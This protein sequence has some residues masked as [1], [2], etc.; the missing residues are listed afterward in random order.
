MSYHFT[1]DWFSRNIPEWR[2]HLAHLDGTRC[3]L[4][5]IGSYEGR[6]ALWMADHL[7]SHPESWLTCVDTWEYSDYGHG[8]GNRFD[9]NV[10]VCPRGQRIIKATG[11]SEDRLK[12]LW[13]GFDFAYI[14]GSHEARD[15]MADWVLTYPLMKP[16]ALVCFDDYQWRN[17]YGQVRLGPKDAIDSILHLWADRIEVVQKG[18][19]VWIRLCQTNE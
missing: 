2:K 5:E 3:R 8:G 14:D 10:A 18:Y 4:L 15:V 9:A 1:D 7:L 6:S 16:G 13:P 19:Q 11:R 12:T 17:P